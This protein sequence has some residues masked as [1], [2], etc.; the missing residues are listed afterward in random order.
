MIWRNTERC[1]RNTLSVN[2]TPVPRAT[3]T[4]PA[5]ST[6]WAATVSAEAPKAANGSASGARMTSA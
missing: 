5:R 6:P 4:A 1:T 2:I 3:S